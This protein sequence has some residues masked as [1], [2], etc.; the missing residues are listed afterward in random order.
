MRRTKSP[1]LCER[2]FYGIKI[3]ARKLWIVVNEHLQYTVQLYS[4][5]LLNNPTY[6]CHDKDWMLGHIAAFVT[7]YHQSYAKQRETPSEVLESSL[8]LER[9][10]LGADL[11]HTCVLAPSAAKLLE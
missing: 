3:T 5:A 11:K 6:R 4:H 10:L 9:R 1:S 2:S 7:E 8:N